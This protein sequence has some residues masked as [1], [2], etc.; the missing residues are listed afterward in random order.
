MWLSSFD[1][2]MGM[3]SLNMLVFYPQSE[4]LALPRQTGAIGKEDNNYFLLMPVRALR[5]C[6]DVQGKRKGPIMANQEIRIVKDKIVKLYENIELEKDDSFHWRITGAVVWPLLDDRQSPDNMLQVKYRYG[7]EKNTIYLNRFNKLVGVDYTQ[8][9]KKGKRATIIA[10]VWENQ[11][12][13]AKINF[14]VTKPFETEVKPNVIFY[15]LELD[16]MG[17]PV[18][19]Y[20]DDDT[21]S[22]FLMAIDRALYF[23]GGFKDMLIVNILSELGAD[24]HL[25]INKV[26]VMLKHL[27]DWKIIEKVDGEHY[28][29]IRDYKWFKEFFGIDLLEVTYKGKKCTHK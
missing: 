5:T 22:A 2:F 6:L 25:L 29:P 27:T 14:R 3:Y 24:E 20:E 10:I 16:I 21:R 11:T 26:R 12:V 7:S 23:E 17:R 19:P 13:Y 18:L 4:N 15:P 9:W 1:I 28:K 8:V